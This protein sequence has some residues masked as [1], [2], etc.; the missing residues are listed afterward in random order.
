MA[1]Q[2]QS[3]PTPRERTADA[4]EDLSIAEMTRIMDVAATLRRERTVAQ[5]ELD[6]DDT[7]RMLRERLLD[8]ARVTGDP[9]TRE[10]IDAAIE[11]YFETQ[12]EF[13]PPAAG[14]ETFLAHLYVL[15]NKIAI[16]AAVLGGGLAVWWSVFGLG[17]LPQGRRR[18]GFWRW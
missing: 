7:K 5:K 3:A 4:R 17:V 13:H 8:T 14:M 9:V 16:G 18:R 1:I 11:H 12:H 2:Q 15:R 6:L 10:E